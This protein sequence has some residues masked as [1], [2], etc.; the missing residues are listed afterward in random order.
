MSQA[1]C[2][3]LLLYSAFGSLDVCKRPRSGGGKI[4]LGLI[5]VLNR[6]GHLLLREIATTGGSDRSARGRANVAHRVGELFVGLKHVRD[7]SRA[8]GFGE[9]NKDAQF[10]ILVVLDLPRDRAQETL[11]LLGGSLPLESV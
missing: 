10:A 7:V 9:A 11:A 1:S 5:H 4:H 3:L 8:F 2:E 6:S